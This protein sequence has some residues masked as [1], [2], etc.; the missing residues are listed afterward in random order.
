MSI[1]FRLDSGFWE[2]LQ[3][4]PTCFVVVVDVV[5]AVVVVVVIVVVIVVVLVKIDAGKG[6]V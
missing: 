2:S 5:V 6:A 3:I 4:V 1:R